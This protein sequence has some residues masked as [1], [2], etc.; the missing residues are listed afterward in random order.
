MRRLILSGIHGI[1]KTK[2]AKIILER[3]RSFEYNTQLYS[4]DNFKIYRNKTFFASQCD[5]LFFGNQK[6]KEAEEESPKIAI[7]DRSL[8]DNILYSKCL[9]T[10]YDSFGK[11]LLSNDEL[12]SIL[13]YYQSLETRKLKVDSLIIFLNPSNEAELVKN[14]QDRGRERGTI[15][16]DKMF[17][18]YLKESFK[19]HYDQYFESPLIE[20]NHYDE[21][22]ILDVLKQCDILQTDYE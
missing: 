9:N 4:L 2:Y 16:E 3:L 13:R 5:R 14:I 11:P 12:T 18:R 17:I 10:Y 19:Q 20:L 15:L 22:D 21:D 6:I 1:G 8:S 7:F